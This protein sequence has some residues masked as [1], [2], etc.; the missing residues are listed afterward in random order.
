MSF[1]L[2]NCFDDVPQDS[3]DDYYM[4]SGYTGGQYNGGQQ[5]DE[6]VVIHS[7]AVR[8]TAL[9]LI[10]PIISE[11][12]LTLGGSAVCL[13][14]KSVAELADKLHI[15]ASSPEDIMHEAKIK[16]N[17]KTQLCVAQKA[18]KAGSRLIAAEIITRFPIEGP[19]DASLLSNIHI[20]NTLAQWATVF[21]GFYPYNFNMKNYAD[22]SFK[23]GR[24]HDIPDTLATIQFAD[25]VSGAH[26]GH[27]YTK[28]ACVINSDVYTGPGKHWMALFADVSAATSTTNPIYT[29]EFFNSS[30]NAPAPEWI[31]WMEKTKIGIESLINQGVLPP[32]EVKIIRVTTLR[33]Q[34]SKSEC[35]L[36]SLFYIWGRLHNVPPSAFSHG[37]IPDKAMFEFRQHLFVDPRRPQLKQFDWEDY[38]KHTH[39]RWE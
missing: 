33:H 21:D 29:V 20:D 11:C 5:I 23:H 30:G 38:Q 13:S 37:D 12:A 35:G 17:C 26:N 24:V 2:S 18:A 15:T 8:N 27:K 39:I 22:Q 31:N 3:D 14:N 16:M 4:N 28:A 10:P 19:T 6:S 9:E 7:G 25:L 36:Y 1:D 34:K 32:G